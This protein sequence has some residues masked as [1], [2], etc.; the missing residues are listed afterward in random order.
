MIISPRLVLLLLCIVDIAWSLSTDQLALLESTIN[1]NSCEFYSSLE[2]LMPCGKNGY[3]IG[4]G[5]RYCEAYLDA[6][7]EFN[8]TKWQNGVRVCLQRT[9]LSKL[10][11]ISEASCSQ[12]SEWGFDSHF[13]CYMHP[14]PDSPEINFCHL[15]SMD[16]IKIGWIATSKLLKQEVLNQ[17][18][19]LIKQCTTHN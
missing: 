9:M 15:K 1:E 4:F 19:K 6:R 17:F 7:N 10:P 2:K 11:T 3:V 13:G 16:I 18:L 14:I 12:I 8:D 5:Y